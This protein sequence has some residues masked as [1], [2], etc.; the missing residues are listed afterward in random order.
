[1]PDSHF[2]GESVIRLLCWVALAVAL[3]YLIAYEVLPA[4]QVGNCNQFSCPR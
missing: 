4:L 1:M 3:Y 2:V